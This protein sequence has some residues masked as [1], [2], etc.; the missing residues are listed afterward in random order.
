VCR[1]AGAAKGAPNVLL[2]MTDDQGYVCRARLAASFRRRRWIGCQR[3]TA[4]YTI[5][6]HCSLLATRAAL[7]TGATI[8]RRFGVVSK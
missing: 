2:I 6:F 4:L 1:L 7:I 3:G 8:T 5:P